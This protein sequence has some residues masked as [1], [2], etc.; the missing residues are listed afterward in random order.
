M[1]RHGRK[2][3]WRIY[4]TLLVSLALVAVLGAVVWRVTGDPQTSGMREL[5]ARVI[6][7]LLPPADAPAAQQQ[8]AIERLAAA[9][10]GR[11]VLT[12]AAG[13]QLAAGPPA[14]HED[15][16][17]WTFPLADGRVLAAQTEAPPWSG[18]FNGFRFI[19]L[20]AL[21]VGLAATP[22]V[23]MLTRRLETLRG[24]VERW[25]AGAL[26][27]RVDERG[28]DEVAAVAIA[29]NRAAARVE[30]LIAAHKSMLAHASHE[31]RSPL[32]R[33]RM[34]IETG[35]AAEIERN[36]AELDGL[37]GE[38]LLASR[39]DH[40]GEP[41]ARE[42]VELLAL[43]A[44]EAAAFEATASGDTVTVAGDRVL[45]RRALRNLLENARRHGAPS[46]EVEVSRAGEAAVVEVRDRGDGV[47]EAERERLF[48]PFHRPHGAAESGGGWGLGLALVRQ[49]ATRHGGSVRCLPR[50]GG[51][52]IFRITLPRT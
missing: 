14:P 41:I 24:G 5:G 8:A 11:I 18:V 7:A 4:V 40:L 2:L 29:F 44:E 1:R 52:T 30:E 49:I 19:A 20:V 6:G 33:L 51:G 15:R 31:L 47:A 50:D 39:L 10:P 32:A 16:H 37:I 26:S 21:G 13:R 17:R 3:F 45:L 34:A 38:I 25:G 12:D 27:H 36:F 35:N 48:E 43:A 23:R 46:V 9:L 22:V 42:P 28:R